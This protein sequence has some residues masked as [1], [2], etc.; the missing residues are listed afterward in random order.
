MHFNMATVLVITTLCSSI[1]LLMNNGDRMF[2]TLAVI[3]SGVQTLLA[4]GLMSLSLA[5]FRVD[6]ILPAILIIAGIVCWMR[7]S[8]K[9]TITASTLITLIAG[10]ELL[11][12]LRILS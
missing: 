3:A 7:V 4:F 9:G 1:Y 10:V 6:A 5:K 12:A 2:P 11:G 8:T